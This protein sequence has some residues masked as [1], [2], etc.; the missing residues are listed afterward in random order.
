MRMD[1]TAEIEGD[2]LFRIR[3]SLFGDATVAL[4]TAR[5]KAPPPGPPPT[6]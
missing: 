6:M 5:G 4:A 2:I 3:R 1:E